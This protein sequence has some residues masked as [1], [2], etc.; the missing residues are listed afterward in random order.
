MVL[1]VKLQRPHPLADAG[2]AAARAGSTVGA[3]TP[4]RDLDSGPTPAAAPS[5]ASARNPKPPATGPIVPKSEAS[6]VSPPPTVASESNLLPKATLSARTAAE[7]KLPKAELSQLGSDQL[8]SSTAGLEVIVS[9][10]S[11]YHRFTRSH[12][13]STIVERP[14][15][16]RAALLGVCA[17]SARLSLDSKSD[18]D[19]S[20]PGATQEGLDK[21][22]T[23]LVRDME[24][25]CLQ[26]STSSSA[27]VSLVKSSRQLCL[28]PPDPAVAFIHANENELISY[29]DT[30]YS[31][32]VASHALLPSAGEG[33]YAPYL[34]KLCRA[35]PSAPI[36]TQES[37]H[38]ANRARTSRTLH[39]SSASH[40]DADFNSTSS[41]DALSHPSEIPD[42]MHQGDLY[43]CGPTIDPA[44]PHHHLLKDL[45]GSGE[46]IRTSLGACASA[47]DRVMS[48]RSKSCPTIP[49]LLTVSERDALDPPQPRVL[50]LVRPPGH[51][52]AGSTPQGFCWTNNVAVA[53]SHA[54][55]QHGVDRIAIFDI[56][57]HHGSAYLVPL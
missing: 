46:A 52:C 54:Y 34:Q 30:S 25:L 13:V 32:S 2:E 51:H 27:R 9:P 49:S 44:D 45:H 8:P 18:N 36:N 1:K 37:P 5:S 38:R 11:V 39:A 43:L 56:D 42:T 15:R 57:L 19:F 53:A 10:A 40:P 23:R 16:I 17:A 28:D 6:R 22:T 4:H 14:E 20:A 24:G 35:A 12:D 7:I 31:R 29:H 3:E 47:V 26:P 48:S 21:E 55:K 33:A 41:E 50:C